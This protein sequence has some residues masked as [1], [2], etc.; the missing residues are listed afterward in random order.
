MSCW[1]QENKPVTGYK[2]VAGKN[3][4]KAFRLTYYFLNN[5]RCIISLRSE[6]L[7]GMLCQLDKDLYP[8]RPL[9][10]LKPFPSPK[11][12]NRHWPFDSKMCPL[13]GNSRF[14]QNIS[15]CE[16]WIFVISMFYMLKSGK[17]S[18][19]YSSGFGVIVCVPGTLLSSHLQNVTIRA[20][21]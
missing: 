21:F 5:K 11:Q 16:A 6:M 9:L 2:N 4:A 15:K 13:L 17:I 3:C 20:C 14:S 10:H 19:K 1:L 8:A 12:F 7:F 18:L